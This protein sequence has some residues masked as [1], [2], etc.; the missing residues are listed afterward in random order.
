MVVW[1][2]RTEADLKTAKERG[3]N[4]VFERVNVEE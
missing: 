2:V 4:F 3:V 1:T